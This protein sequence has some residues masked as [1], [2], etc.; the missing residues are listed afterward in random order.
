MLLA[1]SSMFPLLKFERSIIFFP[2]P[3]FSFGS[4][5]SAIEATSATNGRAG[6][7]SW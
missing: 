4:I 5:H 1:F 2:W 3:S 7:S 6:F